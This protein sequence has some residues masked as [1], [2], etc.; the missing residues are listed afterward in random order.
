[1]GDKIR[2]EPPTVPPG[3]TPPSAALVQGALI[4]MPTLTERNPVVGASISEVRTEVDDAFADMKTFIGRQPDEIMR[5][6]RGHSARLSELRVLIIRV[7]DQFPQWRAVR[8]R[9]IESA[10]DELRDQFLCASRLESVRD[11]DW[12]MEGGSS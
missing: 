7:E 11:L 1:M 3:F 5:I 6:A 2:L 8:T 9:E 10:L 4:P 12:K